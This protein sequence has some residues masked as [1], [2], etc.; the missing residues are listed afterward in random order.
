MYY[1]VKI[2]SF[3][4]KNDKISYKFILALLSEFYFFSWSQV[5]SKRNVIYIV[6]LNLFLQ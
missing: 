3:D 6:L 5:F 2:N 4:R 1:C